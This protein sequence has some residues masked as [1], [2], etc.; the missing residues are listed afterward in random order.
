[1]NIL[2]AN[3]LTT[4]LIAMCLGLGAMA[5]VQSY[6]LKSA[7][8]DVKM[9]QAEIAVLKAEIAVQNNRVKQWAEQAAIARDRADELNSRA[10]IFRA[11]RDKLALKIERMPLPVN[12]CQA[13]AALVDA[14]REATRP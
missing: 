10:I 3:P 1:M 7:Q 6:R 8:A 5:G 14:H 9:A 12:E 2:L 13:L 4:V 11:Q